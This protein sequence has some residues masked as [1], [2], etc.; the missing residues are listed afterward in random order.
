[1]LCGGLQLTVYK[2]LIKVTSI[3]YYPIF[4]VVTYCYV[5]KQ[6]KIIAGFPTQIKAKKLYYSCNDYSVVYEHPVSTDNCTFTFI[7]S[8][9]YDVE[10]P[11]RRLID[12]VHKI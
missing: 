8:C 1:M 4:S 2:N 10:Q 12:N 3:S 11:I 5:P 9:I 7:E 6:N